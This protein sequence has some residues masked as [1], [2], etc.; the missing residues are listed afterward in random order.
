MK[1][2]FTINPVDSPGWTKTIVITDADTVEVRWAEV[3]A[4]LATHYRNNTPAAFGIM[5]MGGLIGEPVYARVIG[6]DRV[7][8]D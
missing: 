7:E 8:D 2:V 4:E 5:F 6:H 3:R 1:D